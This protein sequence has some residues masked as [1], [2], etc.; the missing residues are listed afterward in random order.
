M[1]KDVERNICRVQQ[2]RVNTVYVYPENTEI[3]RKI[4]YYDPKH[5]WGDM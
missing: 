2:L 5:L 4:A 1:E 3:I